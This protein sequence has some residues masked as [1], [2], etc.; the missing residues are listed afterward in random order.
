MGG[1]V[2]KDEKEKGPPGTEEIIAFLGKGTEFKGVI[3]YDGTV[4]IDGHVEGEVV[5]KG[6]LVVGES[7]VIEAEIT[8]GAV[9]C[10]GRITGNIKAEQKVH[11]VSPAV[12]QGTIK[13]PVLLVDE[14]VRFNG[15]C[16][17]PVLEGELA[18]IAGA[19]RMG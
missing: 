16:E 5:T 3:S 13:T 10:G 14:G 12:V 2:K 11:L 6:T 7:A 9:V 18:G 1:M 17:M 4:R 15:S 8:A 19:E